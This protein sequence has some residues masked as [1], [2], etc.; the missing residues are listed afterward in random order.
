MTKV[1]VE[2]LKKVFS[3]LEPGERFR[4]LSG[5]DT[6]F[7]RVDNEGA[8]TGLNAVTFKDG[9]LHT[10]AADVAITPEERGR[11]AVGKV[12]HGAIIVYGGT[13]MRVRGHVGDCVA[14]LDLLEEGKECKPH[15]LLKTDTVIVAKEIVVKT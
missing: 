8:D 9:K 11:I 14:C 4:I 7:M 5:D 10:F 2:P 12:A 6:L 15:T 1:T 3:Q 13:V